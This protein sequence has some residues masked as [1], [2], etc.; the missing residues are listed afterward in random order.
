MDIFTVT[1]SGPTNAD[2]ESYRPETGAYSQLPVSFPA[3]SAR[4]LPG[5]VTGGYLVGCTTKEPTDLSYEI[6]D[7]VFAGKLELPPPADSATDVSFAAYRVYDYRNTESCGVVLL[8]GAVML[9]NHA[10]GTVSYSVLGY[11]TWPNLVPGSDNKTFVIEFSGGGLR[12]AQVDVGAAALRISTALGAGDVDVATTTS[13]I[14]PPEGSVGDEAREYGALVLAKA[15]D[16]AKAYGTPLRVCGNLAYANE[17][18]F[19][20]FLSVEYVQSVTCPDDDGF[21]TVARYGATIEL[22]KYQATGGFT[23]FSPAPVVT[24]P[25]EPV[26]D[27]IWFVPAPPAPP[28]GFWTQFKRAEEQP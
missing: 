3:T 5:A 8:D 17:L 4:L 22:A 25:L 13:L 6:V 15:M 10:A 11:G 12:L 1:S 24:Y 9:I 21:Y 18:G 26:A 23:G 7:Y 27:F 2:V 19:P 28:R 20:P 14:T 16:V